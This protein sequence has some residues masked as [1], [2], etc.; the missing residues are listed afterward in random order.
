MA[1]DLFVI[2]TPATVNRMIKKRGPAHT[3]A[4]R[5]R[6]NRREDPALAF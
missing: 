3:R 2:G 5:A 1:R 6:Q 4:A